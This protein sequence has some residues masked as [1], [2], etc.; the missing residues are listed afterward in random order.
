M[1]GGSPARESSRP[2]RAGMRAH[3]RCGA[4]AYGFAPRAFP[5]GRP[6]LM[7][8]RRRSFAKRGLK[9]EATPRTLF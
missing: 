8:E 2:S 3:G 5:L 7:D 4:S 9:A 6:G 1:K